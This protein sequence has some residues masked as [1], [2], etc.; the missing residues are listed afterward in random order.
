MII[1][2]KSFNVFLPF[3]KVFKSGDDDKTYTV[4]GY[5]STADTDLQGEQILPSGIDDSYLVDNGWIDFEHDINQV[6]GVPTKNTHVDQ[7]GL[8][9]EAKLFKNMPQVQDIMK[10]YHNIKDNEVDRNLGFSIEGNVLER[11]EDDESIV[12]QVQITGVAVTKNP[13]NTHATWELVSK[14]LFSPQTGLNSNEKVDTKNNPM[15]AMTVKIDKSAKAKQNQFNSSTYCYSSDDPTSKKSKHIVKDDEKETFEPKEPHNAHIGGKKVASVDHENK[16]LTAGHG[17]TPSTQS[18]GAA[19]RTEQFSDQIVSIADNLKMAKQ[20]GLEK[21]APT[22][23]DILQGKDAD[24]DTLTVFLQ[25]FTGITNTEA[26]AIVQAVQTKTLTTQRLQTLLG[27]S[28][29]I[30]DD[31]DDDADDDD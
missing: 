10:L 18:N 29:E 9:L 6:I 14:S 30:T 20:I 4:E 26:Q 1:L 25:L 3:D 8:F 31:V 28:D 21:V 5:A 22:I 27:G 12:R 13:A 7:H 17:I 2:N 11:D 23:A 24:D 16:A 15:L 19:F